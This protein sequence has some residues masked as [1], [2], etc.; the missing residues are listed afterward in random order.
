M[1]D[2]D[3]PEQDLPDDVARLAAALREPVAVRPAWRDA[4]LRELDGMPAPRAGAPVARDPS[5]RHRPVAFS[6]IGLAAA[7]VVCIAVGATGMALMGGDRDGGAPAR[8]VSAGP[9]AGAGAVADARLIG[10]SAGGTAVRFVIV[11]P[12]ASRVS[13]VGNFNGW[14]PTAAPMHRVE[15][16]DAWVRD[17]VLAS[18]RHVY[19]FVVDGAIHV[20]PSAPRAVED[21]FGVPSSALVVP[22]GLH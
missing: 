3:H 4:V 16:G 11:A 13:V 17:V 14:N 20:D 21:D 22:A 15:G 1:S 18:G 12:N 10:A 8:R 7:A 2:R 6:P 9:P 5:W 19:A